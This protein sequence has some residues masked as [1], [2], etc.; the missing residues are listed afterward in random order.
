MVNWNSATTVISNI[1]DTNISSIT[2]PIRNV[3]AGVNQAGLNAPNFSNVGNTVQNGVNDVFGAIQ[4]NT[5]SSAIGS[6]N[7][8]FNNVSLST[9]QLDKF[10]AGG[11]NYL[12]E[13]G[14]LKLDNLLTTFATDPG[15]S[16]SDALSSSLD[17]SLF[18][19]LG[20]GEIDA[21][22]NSISGQLGSFTSPADFV[23]DFGFDKLNNVI[24]GF[25]N[26]ENFI[27]NT[28]NVIPKNFESV[29]GAIG[30]DFDVLRELAQD[31]E[32]RS[33]IDIISD[34]QVEAGSNVTPTGITPNIEKNPLKEYNT[35]NYIITLGI[36]TP[37]QVNN[38]Q[39][40]RETGEF[41]TVIC[42]SA[43]GKLDKR[44]RIPLE[45]DL[46][47]HAEY[48]IDNLRTKALIQPNV[49]TGTSVGTD[50]SFDVVEPYSMGN[51]LQSLVE[52]AANAGHE[53]FNDAPFCIKVEFIG[54][55][56]T[57][58]NSS[59]L[60][61][62][63]AY[64]PIQILDSTFE[65]SGQGSNYSI[66]AVP[67]SEIALGD[68]AAETVSDINAVGTTVAD[69]LSGPDKSVTATLNQRITT[70]ENVD[71]IPQGDRY[72][73]AFPKDPTAIQAVVS[74]D[75]TPTDATQVSASQQVQSER[76][77]AS[78]PDDNDVKQETLNNVFVSSPST[79][80]QN[81]EAFAR[82]RNF[83][84]PIGL[85]L[86]LVDDAQSN[87]PPAPDTDVIYDELGD[88]VDVNSTETQPGEKA[89]TKSFPTGSRIDEII[90]KVLVDSEYAAENAEETSESG[91]RTLYRIH[92]HTY[93]DPDIETAKKLGRFP[94]IYVYVVVPFYADEA[95]FAAP[96]AVAPNRG[97]LR[98]SA[99]KE[100]NYIYT[101]KNDDVLNFDINFNNAFLQQAYANF[102]MNQGARSSAGSDRKTFQNTGDQDGAS[103]SNA[104]SERKPLGGGQVVESSRMTITGD[105]RSADIR[106]RLAETFHHRFLNSDVDLITAEMQIM[107]D[108]YYIPT[109]TGNYVAERA[110]GSP[111]ITQEGYMTYIENQV[112]VIVNFKTPIDYSVT[113]DNVVYSE[114]VPEFS[115]IFQVLSVENVFEG[116]KFVQNLDM[117]RS[118]SQELEGESGTFVQ[119]NSDAT[120]NNNP[121]NQISE[122]NA[123]TNGGSETPTDQPC[124]S[125]PQIDTL[126]GDAVDK[127]ANN[128]FPDLSTV[129]G[130][131]IMSQIPS[132]T[133]AGIT[134]SPAKSLFTAPPQLKAEIQATE[135]ALQTALENSPLKI[136][137]LV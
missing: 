86:L 43:G 11:F 38:P 33:G 35:F 45:N 78:T 8:F 119:S 117:V 20:L 16:L 30:G 134:W 114:L 112:Y 29:L 2:A 81:L 66:T 89:I 15:A 1:T 115:G 5:A 60:V 51:F 22:K 50:L 118:R 84:N 101:G 105:S 116:G 103:T 83:M 28:I 12:Q 124:N 104:Q 128:L 36:L 40:I 121:L 63:P 97:G 102:G 90:E 120:V 125:F 106:K 132:V 23:L 58:E 24:G 34:D 56:G 133:V 68:S 79:I 100:Y 113:G 65:V 99:K 73:I 67:L 13:Q 10:Q 6:V 62:S 47:I 137:G 37:E 9:Q 59:T 44:Y 107:G 96:N 52:A 75:I 25:S 109:Q 110:G 85:S 87:T 131:A 123:G 95:S 54:H 17:Q 82:D 31:F 53:S 19:G 135:Q 55:E 69:L 27:T 93:L 70:L 64:I 126:V 3:A 122:G 74:G 32:D 77:L 7:N 57:G 129:A 39:L 98:A 21:L 49:R 18:D 4:N 48:F 61:Q 94:K 42:K 127:V 71:A 26:I 72:I 130:D 91:V 111:S 92:T 108:P 14:S 80:Y 76:G 88:T 46:G 136:R 41:S